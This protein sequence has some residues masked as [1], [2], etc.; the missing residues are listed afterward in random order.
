MKN[1]DHDVTQARLAW[2]IQKQIGRPKT[3]DYIAYVTNNLI[4]SYII[5]AQDIRNVEIIWGA[6]LGNLKGEIV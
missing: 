3:Q 4:P 6:N 2:F 1:S 5:T